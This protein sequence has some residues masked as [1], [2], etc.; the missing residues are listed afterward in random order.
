M[1]QALTWLLGGNR[2]HCHQLKAIVALE[3]EVNNC[4]QVVGEAGKHYSTTSAWEGVAPASLVKHVFL[5]DHIFFALFGL[6]CEK[7][8]AL[9]LVK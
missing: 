7:I 5:P 2:V 4:A 1:L 3:R 6:T 8:F 9:S